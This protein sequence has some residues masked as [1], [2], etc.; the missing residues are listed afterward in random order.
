M[1]HGLLHSPQNVDADSDKNDEDAGDSDHGKHPVVEYTDFC[2]VNSFV[3]S[4]EQHKDT[5]M[6]ML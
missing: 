1:L 3:R 2:N 6:L 5:M 4:S